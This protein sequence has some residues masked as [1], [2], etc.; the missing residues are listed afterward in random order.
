MIHVC[1]ARTPSRP[2]SSSIS[3]P[4]SP[5]LP[6]SLSPSLLSPSQIEDIALVYHRSDDNEQKYLDLDGDMTELIVDYSL[7]CDRSP[8]THTHT[9]TLGSVNS[10]ASQN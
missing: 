10:Y 8:H 6:P 7:I 5:S 4:L 2:L 9:H 3:L 1:I